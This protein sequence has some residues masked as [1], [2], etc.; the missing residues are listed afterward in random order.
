MQR[1][2]RLILLFLL[3]SLTACHTEPTSRISEA[4][5]Q[6]KLEGRYK[7]T[8]VAFHQDVESS[9]PVAIDFEPTRK[10][11]YRDPS[12]PAPCLWERSTDGITIR[13]TEGEAL[14]F[15]LADDKLSYLKR[16]GFGGGVCIQLVKNGA[17]SDSAAGLCQGLTKG[18]P[19]PPG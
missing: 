9:S 10:C 2:L 14:L 5:A 15:K 19:L 13:V 3:S 12:W 4:F 1:V 18:L 17:V 6:T 16:D 8:K 7:G 11:R